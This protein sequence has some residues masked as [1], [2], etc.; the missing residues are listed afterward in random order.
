[1]DRAVLE[2]KVDIALLDS[3]Y[4]DGIISNDLHN[5]ACAAIRPTPNWY[6]W[7]RR[8][9]LFLGAALILAGIVFFF[10]YNWADMHKFLK[11]GVIEAGMIGCV[12]GVYYLGLEKLSGKILLLSASVLTGVLMAVFGQTYQTGADPYELF[13]SWA[14]LILGWAII[15]DFAALWIVWLI[16]LNT[17][18]ILYWD[19]VGK[20]VYEIN[21][22]YL[23]LFLAGLN[24][25]ALALR[26][27]GVKVGRKWLGGEWLRI[28]LFSAIII[29]LTIPLVGVIIDLKY[30]ESPNILTC[31]F[32]ITGIVAGFCCY[33]IKIKDINQLALIILD[34]CFIILFFIGKLMFGGYHYESFERYFFFALIILIV[35]GLACFY[36]RLLTKQIAKE[37]KNEE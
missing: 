27:W 17:G 24:S 26:E 14:V 35:V 4:E 2:H 9:L 31:F 11:F 1:M 28:C 30:F 34:V 23:F 32:W 5:V 29:F 25:T 15:S 21:S 13:I 22:Q 33:R 6:L 19:Q 20:P 16:I 3:L 8:M 12:I 18:V 36:L 37:G 10:A 7:S